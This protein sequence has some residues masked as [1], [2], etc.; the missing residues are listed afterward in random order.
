MSHTVVD[1]TSS[2]PSGELPPQSSFPW[3]DRQLPPQASQL[4]HT[5]KRRRLNDSSAGPSSASSS[6]AW[7]MAPRDQPFDIDRHANLNDIEAVDLTGGNNK[8]QISK[9]LSKQQED[10][11]KAQQHQMTDSEDGRS[12]LATYKCPV[13]MDTPEDATSTICGKES[14]K[15]V[16]GM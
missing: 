14:L 9:T 7:S 11:V 2:S 8:T 6:S 12:I 3:D 16:C 5:I 4:P 1:L 10:A 15:E 13:C